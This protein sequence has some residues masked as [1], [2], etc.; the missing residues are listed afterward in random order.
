MRF[1]VTEDERKSIGSTA[2]IEFQKG[3]YDGNCWHIDSICM[4]DDVFGE[5]H[6]RRFFSMVLPQFDYYGITQVS[7]L[8]FEK[9]KETAVNFS[10]DVCECI[11]E[12]EG[13]IGENGDKD[14][15]FTICGM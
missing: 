9:L 5:L 1:F 15:L 7:K 13:W 2:F 6:L 12:L 11:K 14:I 8:E 10:N 4:D 3:E